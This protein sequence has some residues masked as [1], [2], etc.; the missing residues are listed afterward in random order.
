MPI[1]LDHTIVPA[2]DNEASARFFARIFGLQV[3]AAV[4]H[5]APIRVNDTLVLDFVSLPDIGSNGLETRIIGPEQRPSPIGGPRRRTVL[6][7][8]TLC[9]CP[10]SVPTL[11]L[12]HPMSAA[13]VEANWLSGRPI[14]V[15]SW[16]V[17]RL[18]SGRMTPS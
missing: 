2:S 8:S 13:A 15:R 10:G 18:C 11:P 5:F 14:P 12:D 6:G 4:S 7:S 9:T 1:V 17:R 3:E 16:S